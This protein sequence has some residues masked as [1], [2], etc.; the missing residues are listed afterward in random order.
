[1]GA[2]L[3]CVRI[4]A[5]WC[6]SVE[7]YARWVERLTDTLRDGEFRTTHQ[8]IAFDERG[9]LVDGQ[10]RL[11]AIVEAYNQEGEKPSSQIGLRYWVIP[12]RLQVDGTLGRQHA[13]PQNR[14]WV[15]AGGRIL[16]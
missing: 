11:S 16:F 13:D 9:Q 6:T 15:S 14:T 3:E 8:G 1:M 4:G 7:A 5:I 12:S 2:R 10:N